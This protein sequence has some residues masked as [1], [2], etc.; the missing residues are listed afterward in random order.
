[1]SEMPF[2]L[3]ARFCAA[4]AASIYGSKHLRFVEG[5]HL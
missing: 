3:P 4:Y 1:M 5:E 2:F